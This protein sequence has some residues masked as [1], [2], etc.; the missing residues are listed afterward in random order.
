MSLE[1]GI[2]QRKGMAMGKSPEAGGSFG[3]E[4]L[5]SIN[6]GPVRHPDAGMN[7]GTLLPEGSRAVNGHVSRGAGHMPA[8]KHPDHGPHF[9]RAESGKGAF[10][11]GSFKS[12]NG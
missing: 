10:D 2:R 6:G 4:S 5:H 7:S 3:V 9:H 11:V 12:M 1:E 8:Q